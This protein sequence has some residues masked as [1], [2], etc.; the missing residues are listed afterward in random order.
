MFLNLV[1]TS[2]GLE[3]NLVMMSTVYLFILV[4]EHLALLVIKAIIS[5]NFFD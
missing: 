2:C 1:S 4:A 3:L 5:L